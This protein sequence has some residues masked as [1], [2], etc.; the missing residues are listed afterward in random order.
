MDVE[1]SKV[2]IKVEKGKESLSSYQTKLKYSYQILITF[3]VAFCKCNMER[4]QH[5]YTLCIIP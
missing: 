4:K 3:K 5:T 1:K 2:E